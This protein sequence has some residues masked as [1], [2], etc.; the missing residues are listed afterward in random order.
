MTLF[1]FRRR[2]DSTTRPA[3]GRGFVSVPLLQTPFSNGGWIAISGFGAPPNI[4]VRVA[5]W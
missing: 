2:T 4:A 5:L 3:R 1:A